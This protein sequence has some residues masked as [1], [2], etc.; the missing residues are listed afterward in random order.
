MAS[1]YCVVPLCK[2]N[3][4][5][6]FGRCEYYLVSLFIRIWELWFNKGTHSEQFEWLILFGHSFNYWVR[7]W[8]W[9][10]G[11]A[12]VDDFFRLNFKFLKRN[13]LKLDNS[14]VQISI[15]DRKTLRKLRKLREF[16][17]FITRIAMVGN[18]MNHLASPHPS[19]SKNLNRIAKK[20][21]R[22]AIKQKWKKISEW[23][24][25]S[26]LFSSSKKTTQKPKAN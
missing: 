24:N 4:L 19:I 23:K 14:K 26:Q 6:W 8:L 2:E 18:T 10:W 25:S 13:L 21:D 11:V 7:S 22:F 20:H 5:C 16:T 17:D 12:Y 3:I 1:L 15:E 9:F